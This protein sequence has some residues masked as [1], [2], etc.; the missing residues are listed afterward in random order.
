MKELTLQIKNPTGLHAR[1]ARELVNVAKTCKADI[2]LFH[3]ERKGNA[4]NLFSVLKLGVAAGGELHIQVSGED[5]S[6]A[7]EKLREAVLSGLGETI[8]DDTQAD[9]NGSAPAAVNATDTETKAKVPTFEF[10]ADLTGVA[11][12]NGIALGPVFHFETAQA[13]L[14][15][16]FQGLVAEQTK[17]KTA[18]AAADAELK[19]LYKK[20]VDDGLP[21]AAEIFAV[22]A[23]L[24][25]DESLLESVQAT[26][27]TGIKASSA[28]QESIAAYASELAQM[29][30]EVLAARA[31]DIRDVGRRVG[32]HLAGTNTTRTLP[33]EPVIIVAEELFPSDTAAFDPSKVLGIITSAGGAT[34]HA[35]ILARALAVPAIVSAGD[36]V[37][38]YANG[39][40]VLFDGA[41]GTIA[42]NPN[43]DLQA[44]AKKALA[45]QRANSERL[46]KAAL[47][48]AKTTD[49]HPLEIG[50]NAG[51]LDDVKRG[52]DNGCDGVGLFRT[53]FLYLGRD[54]APTAD[55]QLKIYT[56]IVETLGDRPL[57]IR[58]LDIGGDKIVPY[59]DLPQESNP[60][61]G[62]RG[63]RLSLAHPELFRTQLRTIMRVPN[64]SNV[65]IMFPMIATLADWRK[66]R[67]IVSEVQAECNVETVTVGM[68]V[69]VPSAA[70]LAD[71]FAAEVDFF[72][73][74][75]N[76][77]TQYTL[78]MDRTNATLTA[79]L[80]GLHPAVL[81]LIDRVVQAA[82]AA[83]KWVGI[84]GELGGDVEA[85]P[86]L[87]GLGVQELSVAPP[88]VGEIKA[89]VRSLSY[90]DS[91]ALAQQALQQS[92][93]ADVR[94]LVQKHVN[95]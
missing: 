92:T 41:Q 4:K 93:A 13:S 75:T 16:T 52:V 46:R 71:Q 39:T 89:R 81:R 62:V 30:N 64:L 76:D 80:D 44:A 95:N 87:L 69:E 8:P 72:S 65:K 73:I 91:K 35:A 6:E 27:K 48:G 88:L 33:D 49:G 82:Q 94:T 23:D 83:G 43:A 51:S 60:F 67:A 17:L 19:G 57:I 78:A 45:E 26:I 20:L 12:S 24:I 40:T 31:N 47:T 85:V 37:L 1:P 21:D 68:M 5:E 50:S 61:L 14:N 28:W 58:T 54:T 7:A 53:E 55:E 70:I 25:A 74:G 38:D 11:A 29:D 15:D 3:G 56:D 18:L 36:A 10:P 79:Q 90:A 2:A 32:Q 84:C 42:V 59:L 9:V 66:A 22:H 63:V 34:D 77:L 86:V